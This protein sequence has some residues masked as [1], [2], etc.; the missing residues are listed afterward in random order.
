MRQTELERRSERIV[1]LK[2]QGLSCATIGIRLGLSA[3]TVRRIAREHSQ[4][5]QV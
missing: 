3:S 1:V 4:K 5:T 2:A